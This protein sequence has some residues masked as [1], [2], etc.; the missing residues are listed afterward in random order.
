MKGDLNTLKK[1]CRYA[2]T[3]MTVGEI[4]CAA[5]A[6][7]VIA[8]GAWSFT[9]PSVRGVL[10]SYFGPMSDISLTFLMVTGVALFATAFVTVKMVRDLMGSYLVEDSPFTVGN[11]S[12]IKVVSLTFLAAAAI[13]PITCYIAMGS[14]ALCLFLFFGCLLVCVV[15]YCLTIV[16]R[17]GS[18]LQDESDHTL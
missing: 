15:M 13:L 6:V 4:A 1:V 16:F 18:V 8:I 10:E 14:L 7:A 3:V 9:D 2:S 17:Y 12:R 5:L 11:A